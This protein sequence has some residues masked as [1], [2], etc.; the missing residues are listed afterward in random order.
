MVIRSLPL[1]AGVDEVAREEVSHIVA[2]S[3]EAL[4]AGRPL[5]VALAKSTETVAKVE[6]PPPPAEPPAG[7]WISVG[8]GAGA[9]LETADDAAPTLAV[10]VLVGPESRRFAPALWLH[11]E[12]FSSDTGGDPVALRFRG[13]ALAVLGAVGTSAHGR[14]VVRFGL[15]PGIE[16]RAA[17]PSVAGGVAAPDGVEL[18]AT[19][20]DPSLFVRAAARFEVRLGARVGLFA[21][22]ACDA[23][24][25]SHRYLVTRDDGST[26]TA[27]DPDRLRPS[28]L[29]GVDARLAGGAG[30]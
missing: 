27:Y 22:A 23:R 25:V 16:L 9:A 1:P 8:V 29:V 2:S 19:R 3:V 4:Q 18:S 20:L 17:T 7:H 28:I 13:G 15:G 10:S 11:A 12:G 14:A 30:P 5:P 6:R 21:V 24:L 26:E